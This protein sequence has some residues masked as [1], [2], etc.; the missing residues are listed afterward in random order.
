MSQ[1]LPWGRMQGVRP[2][3]PFQRFLDTGLSPEQAAA[4]MQSM[5]GV[6]EEKARLLCQVSQ[7]TRQLLADMERD[8]VSIYVG[9]PFCPTRCLYCSFPS[10]SLA[11]LG[12]ERGRF[13][14]QLEEEIAALGEYLRSHGHP[15]DSVYVGGGTPTALSAADLGRVLGTL[16][17][18]MPAGW[19]EFTVEAGRPE[20]LTDQLLSVMTEHGVERISVNPQ[21]KHDRTLR[22]IG[23][24][25][26]AA[27]IEHAYARCRG[28]FDVI[29]MD[30]ILGL[31]GEGLAEVQ[32]SLH[33]VLGMRPENITLHMFSPK[34]ASRFSAERS[35]WAEQLPADQ[36]ARAMTAWCYRELGAAGYRPY[37]LYRQRNILGGQENIGWAL[38]GAECRYNALM[39][40]ERQTI[41]GLGGGASSKFIHGDG[42]VDTL[43]NPKDVLVYLHRMPELIERKLRL[44]AE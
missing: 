21:T 33:W 43:A 6:S 29:N 42:S 44:L 10:H 19:R 35:T 15:I 38:P 12:R 24:S 27:D 8:A 16:R 11:E 26:R 4:R 25:H 32:Q 9:I 18:Q 22:A 20:T 13:V 41:L 28:L 36:E 23:R 1:P 40:E 37:Y 34:R 30:L 17:R 5:Y 3:K 39:I 7:F 14:T 2:S 31:P